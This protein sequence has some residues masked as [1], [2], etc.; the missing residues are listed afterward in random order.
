MKK[1][2]IIVGVLTVLIGG[3]IFVLNTGN[4]GTPAALDPEGLIVPVDL[5]EIG[6]DKA[7]IQFLTENVEFAT[8]TDEFDNEIRTGVKVPIKYNFPV[9]SSTGF[10]VEE[11]KGVME[12]T[13]DGYNMCRFK[14][15]TKNL[16]LSELRDDIESNILTFQKNV[17]R[18]LEELKQKGFQDEIILGNI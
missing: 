13:L 3:T 12:M 4:V 16:C 11:I 10:V 14:G 6:F 7:D 8:S 17:E 2:I 18:E 5:K 15:G 9:A 1:T